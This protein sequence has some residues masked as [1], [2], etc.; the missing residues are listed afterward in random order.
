[1]QRGGIIGAGQWGQNLVRV[2][3]Q[4][5]SGSVYSVCDIDEV[6]LNYIN[7]LYPGVKTTFNYRE[8]LE[9]P[10]ISFVCI[11]TPANTHYEIAKMS[12][13]SNKQV[14]VEKPLAL[15]VSQAEELVGLALKKKLTLMVG[16]IFEYNKAINKLKNYIEENVL[17]DIFYLRSIRCNLG[18][19]RQDVSAMW[20]LAPHDISIF[21]YLLNSIPRK[22]RAVGRSFFKSSLEDV[23]FITLDFP[24]NIMGSI[25][26]SWL[27]PR[28]I[29]EVTVVGSKK[30]VVFDDLSLVEPIRLYDKG[31]EREKTY[32]T[33]GEFQMVLRDGDVT[34]PKIEMS[35]PLK[36]ECEHFLDCIRKGRKPLSDGEEGLKVV[37]VLAAVEKSMKEEGIPVEVE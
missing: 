16:H 21:L 13:A 12:L 28:K 31:I 2:F 29:R 7:K 26:V 15:E 24:N 5:I 10:A 37:K 30:M 23:A 25:Q 8:I 36:A 20:D 33:F 14:L 34:I 6:C 3:N 11:A 19:Y 17:G 9:D 35:E 1:M 18:P 22:V 4:L 32:E 27:D